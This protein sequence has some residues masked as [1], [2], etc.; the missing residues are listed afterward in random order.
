MKRLLLFLVLAGML[1]GGAS[2]TTPADFENVEWFS[3]TAPSELTIYQ[4][5]VNDLGEGVTTLNLDAYGETYVFEL[6]CTR[7]LGWWNF[8]LTLTYPNSTTYEPAVIST[9]QPFATDYD[10]KIQ[11]I[12]SELDSV[13]D[14]DFY[15]DLAPGSAGLTIPTG[16]R[17]FIL[18]S[19][20]SGTLSDPANVR[21]YLGTEEEIDDLEDVWSQF[22]RSISQVT[23]DVF[24][25]TWDMILTFVGMIPVVG[26]YFAEFLVL[27]GAVVAELFWYFNFF[28]IQEPEITFCLVECFILG[29]AII[30]GRSFIRM[31][32]LVYTDNLK[33]IA[34]VVAVFH[35]MFDLL[36]RFVD[37]VT[38]I[39]NAMKPV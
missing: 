2:A 14:V 37:F 3:Y 38:S 29:H 28:V 19:S 9:L 4:I 25:W 31:L 23:S 22:T 11:Y 24:G 27:F 10:V 21:L 15:V 18:F 30:S 34:G 20:A 26:D 32:Q 35:I 7:S 16:E 33:L 6:N 36:M 5:S 1:I 12:T 17:T 13:F 8:D 39:I